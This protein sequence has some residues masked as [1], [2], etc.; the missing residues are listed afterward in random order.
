MHQENIAVV[1][2][3]AP[4]NRDPKYMEQ[5]LTELKAQIDSSATVIGYFNTPFAM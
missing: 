5:T 4:N 3:H 2:I 1:N